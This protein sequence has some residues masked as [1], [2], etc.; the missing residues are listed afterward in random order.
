MTRARPNAREEFGER[1]WIARL[2]AMDVLHA[3]AIGED[4]SAV[5]VSAAKALLALAG[6]PAPPVEPPATTE[7]RLEAALLRLLEG[8]A[9]PPRK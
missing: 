5:R 3:C 6:P 8:D 4:I 2:D 1:Y 9:G 7:S